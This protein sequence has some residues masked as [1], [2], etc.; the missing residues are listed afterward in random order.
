MSAEKQMVEAT[1]ELIKVEMTQIYPQITSVSPDAFLIREQFLSQHMG[2]YESVAKLFKKAQPCPSPSSL[3]DSEEN[4]V[5]EFL[6][7]YTSS[8]FSDR[9][10]EKQ[11]YKKASSEKPKM[12]ASR[13]FEDQKK[14]LIDEAEKESSSHSQEKLPSR[15]QTTRLLGSHSPCFEERGNSELRLDLVTKGSQKVKEMFKNMTNMYSSEENPS[16]ARNSENVG[17]AYHSSHANNKSIR[18]I[19]G[20]FSESCHKEERE[21]IGEIYNFQVSTTN[22]FQRKKK[23]CSDLLESEL[24]RTH[25]SP[26]GLQKT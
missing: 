4:S 7:V 13:F 9:K 20:S 8:P 5:K 21:N 22:F 14:Y 17:F 26:H 6:K 2:L 12:K 24:I 15:S 11:H 3:V 19:E 1:N 16:S 10:Q 23:E 25:P 18:S